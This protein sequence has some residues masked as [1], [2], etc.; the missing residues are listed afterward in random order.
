[1]KS[2]K[3]AAATIVGLLV[4]AVSASYLVSKGADL[5]LTKPKL[6]ETTCIEFWFSRYQTILASL[7]A[8]AIALSALIPV[9]RQ[10]NLANKQ[11]AAAAIAP[12]RRS[13]DDINDEI[14]SISF[15]ESLR[16]Q[17]RAVARDVADP[18]QDDRRNE[19][20]AEIEKLREAIAA[21]L[22]PIEKWETLN[23][24]SELMPTRAARQEALAALT[25]QITPLRHWRNRFSEEGTRAN[26]ERLVQCSNEVQG[27]CSLENQAA[28]AHRSML[29]L[30]GRGYMN[31]IRKFEQHAGAFDPDYT[32]LLQDVVSRKAK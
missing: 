23:T 24:Q 27:A 26:L 1:M 12:L 9:Y 2:N 18:G 17:A 3:L 5:C 30:T 11:H 31:Q 13:I 28:E 32:R 21:Y 15:F 10:L 8:G 7:V 4:A 6:V 16:E 29:L 25:T 20:T 22:G 14:A 19:F